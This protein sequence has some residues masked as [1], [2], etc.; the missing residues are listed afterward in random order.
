MRDQQY[1]VNLTNGLIHKYGL[2]EKAKQMDQRGFVGFHSFIDFVREHL[3]TTPEIKKMSAETL[4]KII[5][6]R[7]PSDRLT[8]IQSVIMSSLDNEQCRDGKELL[9]QIAAY[10]LANVI[11][12]RLD[13]RM[14][15]L[16]QFATS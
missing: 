6:S 14:R 7:E 2:H 10:H 11:R 15:W 9:R 5:G 1:I 4:G 8:G 12:S 16:P 13:P 3:L